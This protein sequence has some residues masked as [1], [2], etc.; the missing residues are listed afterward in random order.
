MVNEIGTTALPER[1]EPE[2]E[3]RADAVVLRVRRDGRTVLDGVR[4]G[5]R[6]GGVD[7]DVGSVLLRSRRRDVTGEW[8]AWSGKATGT[9][10]YAHRETV[11]ELRHASGLEWQIHVR[12]G[13]D[14]VAVRYVLARLEGHGR[15]DADRTRLTFDA[16]ARVWA[17]DY[18]TW[19]ETPRFGADVAS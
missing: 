7:L 19:Y 5:I 16:D 13:A 11:H 14:G 15:L 8:T 10:R 9:H 17:L 18:Q 6:V 2:V 4:L 12:A 3:T 1:L